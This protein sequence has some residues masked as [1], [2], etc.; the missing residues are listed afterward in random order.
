[1]NGSKVRAAG[2]ALVS[3]AMAGLAASPALASSGV[4]VGSVSSLKAGAKAGTLRGE[5]INRTGKAV[6]AKVTVR[7]QRTGA[8]AK[9]VGNTAV[10]VPA[11][12]S[13]A[14]TVAVKLPGGL[15]RGNYYLAA[16]TPSGTG[17]G[18]LG[19]ATTQKDIRIK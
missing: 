12:A 4:T 2:V 10:R 18:E 11:N 1:M 17:A 16:C 19:C 13:A 9:F 15:S 8:A 14:Y 3:V 6:D 7:I 5:V